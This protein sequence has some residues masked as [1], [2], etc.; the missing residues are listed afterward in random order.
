MRGKEEDD[1]KEEGEKEEEEKEEEEENVEGQRLMT[2]TRGWK[3]K[4]LVP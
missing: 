2:M 4:T 1:E 3:G